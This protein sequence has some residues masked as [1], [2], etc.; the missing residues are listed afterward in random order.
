MHTL[1]PQLTEDRLIASIND[2]LGAPPRRLR[3]GIGDDAAVWK[4]AR[5]HLSLITTDM[6]VDD[7]HFRA[8][9]TSARALGHKALAVN[10]SDIAAMG[11]SPTLAVVALGITDIVGEAWAR[12]FYSGMAK[13]A[14]RS[15]CAIAGG[16]IVRAPVLTIAVTVVGEVRKSGLRLRSGAKPGDYACVT[17]PLGLAA[18]GLRLEAGD[19]QVAEASAKIMRCAYETPAPRL[20]EGQFLG[21]SRATHA[22]MDISD[23]L[24]L[25][26]ARMARASGADACL[27]LSALRS[28]PA[29]DEFIRAHGADARAR[30]SDAPSGQVSAADLMLHG[31]DDYELLVAIEPRALG[32]VARRF[33]TR[34]KRDLVTVGR[35]EKGSG[36]LWIVEGGKR[37]EHVPRGYDHL[38]ER[39]LVTP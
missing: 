28:H 1:T 17:G 39:N 26:L 32:H 10:L 8:A 34:F 38:A 2:A 14:R 25:D 12:E 35:F 7:V 9:S 29:L 5:S 15:A 31:G 21:S 36:A 27:D 19:R 11:G 4:A 20:A 18:A 23:G 37:R 3:V 22:M 24:S 6:L 13:L 16:D 30:A 33:K